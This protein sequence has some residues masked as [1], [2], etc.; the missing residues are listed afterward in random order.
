[1]NKIS[2][3]P[4]MKCHCFVIS[5][6]VW[7]QKLELNSLK[8]EILFEWHSRWYN[9]FKFIN[10]FLY[11]F[12]TIILIR[13]DLFVIFANSMSTISP[14]VQY[15]KTEDYDKN[16]RP[17]KSK[18]NFQIEVQQVSFS[19]SIYNIN[20]SCFPFISLVFNLD[21]FVS[22]TTVK[23]YFRLFFLHSFPFSINKFSPS[24]QHIFYCI[25][26]KSKRKQIIFF[27]TFTLRL[28]LR[29][30]RKNK[31]LFLI[32]NIAD[33]L[34]FFLLCCGDS[35]LGNSFTS[36][37]SRALTSCMRGNSRAKYYRK[38]QQAGYI[39]INIYFSKLSIIVYRRT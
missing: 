39:I 38:N 6:V 1:M 14:S 29:L 23:W 5:D 25:F 35:I 21:G 8:M 33:V 2:R 31:K 13:M 17:S 22:F 15:N 10:V 20:S 18:V 28:L 34:A 19:L 26:Q 9:N 3:A 4:S 7:S 12:S 11:F 16:I 24:N 36:R 27:F 37:I 30:L 32:K